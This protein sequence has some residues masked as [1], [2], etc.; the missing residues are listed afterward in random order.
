[1]E[2]AL[3]INEIFW[4]TK[5]GTENKIRT[6]V[7]L[8]FSQSV[9]DTINVPHILFLNFF[10]LLFVEVTTFLN[11]MLSLPFIILYLHFWGFSRE[12]V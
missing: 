12:S 10:S 7:A 1:M 4:Y 5:K 2:I 3:F 11:L 8:L 6:F 9:T